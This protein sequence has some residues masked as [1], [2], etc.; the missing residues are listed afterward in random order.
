ML[1]PACFFNWS[2]LRTYIAAVHVMQACLDQHDPAGP[3]SV[4][5]VSEGLQGYR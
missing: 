2:C 3:W 1:Q 4:A 5:C